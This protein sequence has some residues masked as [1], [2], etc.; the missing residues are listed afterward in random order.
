MTINT[1]VP[2][3]TVFLQGLLSFFS[4]CVLPLI[5]VYMGYLSG[6]TLAKDEEGVWHYD[7]KKVLI[8]TL[9]FTIGVSFAF[10]LLGLGISAIGRFFSGNQLI[11][12]RVGGIIVVAFGLY[13]L[14]VFG[15]SEILSGELRLPFNMSKMTMSPLVAL[16]F[17]FVLSFAWSPCIG[18]VLSS[19]LIMAAS[20]GGSAMGFVLIGVYTIGYIIPFLL[21]GVFTTS[22]LEFF[23]KHRNVVKYTVKIGGVILV[24]MGLLMIT[25]KMNGISSYLSKISGQSGAVSVKE[26]EE[27]E[28]VAADEA[29]TADAVDED[30]ADTD[31]MAD[32]DDSEDAADDTE[33]AGETGEASNEE[34]SED[35]EDEE[36]FPA[37]E[38]TLT[39]QYGNTHSIADY[40]GKIIFLNFWATWCPPCRAELPYIQELYTEYSANP[41]ADTVFLTVAFP[42]SGGEEDIDGIKSFLD[43][44]GYTFPVLMDETAEL[45]APYYISAFPTTYIISPEGNVL[46]YVP[47][48]MTKD[49][50]KDVLD[51][52]R[53]MIK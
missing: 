27:A 39:D 9:F 32:V 3:L 11:F 37:P 21:V 23:G 29:E 36:V 49:I 52:A 4:P 44:N 46:G 53:E 16:I 43:E 17:G 40:R 34:A 14:G 33:E 18:P 8:N 19:V 35:T 48:G 28:E 12:A 26:T 25:G 45:Q 6:G 20:A 2:A 1:S 51:Q 15:K 7:R 50:M 5:P 31:D 10:F 41:D 22:L 30:D 38:F 24:I 42:N 13:Q 47:G